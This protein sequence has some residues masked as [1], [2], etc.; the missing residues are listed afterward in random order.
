MITD[1]KDFVSNSLLRVLSRSGC[2]ITRPLSSTPYATSPN[3]VINCD[4]LLLRDGDE[5]NKCVFVIKDD[6]KSY[7]RISSCSGATVA[8]AAEQ[9]SRWQRTFTAPRYWVSDQGAHLIN[10]ILRSMEK[11]RPTVAYSP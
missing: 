7:A 6:L 3:K 8:H 4:Y 9:L 2:K 1:A 11:H 5:G 10:D